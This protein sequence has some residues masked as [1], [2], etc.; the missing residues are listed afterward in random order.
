MAQKKETLNPFSKL[1]AQ[2]W[3]NMTQEEKLA[4]LMNVLSEEEK[5]KLCCV[6]QGMAIAQKAEDVQSA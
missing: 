4:K 5:E 1:T 2:I 3:E 6:A